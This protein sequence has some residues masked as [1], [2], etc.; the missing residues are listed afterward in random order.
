[1]L[2]TTAHRLTT[3]HYDDFVKMVRRRFRETR[4]LFHGLKLARQNEFL[5][6][7]TDWKDLMVFEADTGPPEGIMGIALVDIDALK[8][9]NREFST[10]NYADFRTV[11]GEAFG[12]APDVFCGPRATPRH[13]QF[14]VCATNWD[15]LGRYISNTGEPE[16][17][18]NV[19]GN[20]ERLA[21][22]DA[23]RWEIS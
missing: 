18:A 5:A 8:W 2:L 13:N 14:V 16:D 7:A 21:D 17:F 6:Y 10:T 1:M 9:G 20:V 15:Y 23:L 19:F 11:A 4:V 12:K 3:T 22:I